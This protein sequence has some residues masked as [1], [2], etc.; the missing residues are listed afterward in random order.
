MSG[1]RTPPL[2]VATFNIRNGRAF[3]GR[4]SWW[5]RRAS[6]RAMVRTLDADVLGLQEAYAFQVRYLSAGLCGY[7]MVGEG[8]GGGDK[9]E[10]CVLA[11]RHARAAL[12]SHE[13]RWFGDEPARPSRLVGAR[14]ERIATVASYIDVLA[15][16]PFTVINTHLDERL[17]H[18]RAASAKQLVGWLPRNEPSMV[19]GDLNTADD[20]AV[21]GPLVR[22]GLRSVL[23]SSAP[24]TNH[25]FRGNVAGARLDHIMVS[26]H[27]EI[28]DAQVVTNYTGRLPSDH[29]PVRAELR[30]RH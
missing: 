12:R 25:D 3:D 30:W 28:A 8:R 22:H 13:T 4:N 6:T 19:M 9:G 18:L 23:A 24:G 17:G 11:S 21:I 7:Q 10:H 29:W 20:P 1:S 15:G 2:V 16:R 27:F 26:A 14:F 5:F